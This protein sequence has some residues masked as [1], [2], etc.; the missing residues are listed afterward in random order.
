M[1]IGAFPSAAPQVSL[2]GAEADVVVVAHVV[3]VG[4]VAFAP[5]G[6]SNMINGG[7]A[8]RNL[9]YESTSPSGG[10]VSVT[11]GPSGRAASAVAAG[12]GAKELTFN[13][14]VR[15]HGDLLSYCSREPDV[16]LLN[17]VRLQPEVDYSF[18]AGVVVEPAEAATTMTSADGGRLRVDVPRVS[19]LENLVQLVFRSFD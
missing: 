11:G 5:L 9:R 15:G 2:R 19:D 8:V 10:G 13:M 18:T 7:G 16:V 6:L 17:G 12:F 14:M 1:C 4:P 3:R